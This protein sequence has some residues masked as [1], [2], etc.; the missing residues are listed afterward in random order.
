MGHTL[1][2]L[3]IGQP[4]LVASDDQQVG[5]GEGATQPVGRCT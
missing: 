2:R 3:P 1:R 4:N 5:H